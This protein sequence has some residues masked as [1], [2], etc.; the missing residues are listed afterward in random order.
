MVLAMFRFMLGCGGG[1]W[2]YCWRMELW[3]SRSSWRISLVVLLA[4]TASSDTLWL[5]VTALELMA[6]LVA[7]GGG[8]T[9]I[10]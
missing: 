9:A 4:V 7:V 10:N 1:G 5:L 2:R 8:G 6:L 3:F